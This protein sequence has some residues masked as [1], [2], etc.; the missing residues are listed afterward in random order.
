MVIKLP[1]CTP[2]PLSSYLKALGVLRL[3]SEA[4]KTAKVKG[5]WQDD[6]FVLVSDL[7]KDELKQ[8][9][10]YEYKPTPLVAPWNGSTGFYPKDNRKTLDSIANAQAERLAE[11]R[12]TVEVAQKQVDAL[13]LLEQPKE[14]EQKKQLLAELR[15][16]LPDEAV[17]WVETCALI[18]EEKLEF[19]PLTGTGGNDGN[20]EFSRTFMQQ[21][22]ELMNFATGEPSPNAQMLLRAAIFGEIVPELTFSGKIG[23]FNPI[24][25]GGANAAP[26]F[27]ADSR[28][29]PWDFVLMLEGTLLFAAG[30]TRRYEQTGLGDFVYPFTVKPSR[31]GYGSASEQDEARA[32]I[33]IPLWSKP[34]GIKELQI[35][36]NEGRAKIGQRTAQTGVDFARAISNLGVNRGISEFIRYSFQVRNGLSYFAMPLGRFQPRSNPQVD[37][38]AILDPWLLNFTQAAKDSEAP[39]SVKLARRQLETAIIDLTRDKASLLDVLIALGAAEK[40]LANSLK[41]AIAKRLQ[42]LPILRSSGWLTDC[43]KTDS[44]REFRLALSLTTLG[45]QQRRNQFQLHPNCFLATGELR[46]RLVP[47]RGNTPFWQEEKDG[48]TTWQAGS[49]LKNLIALLRRMEIETE[50]QEKQQPA[51]EEE[52]ARQGDEEDGLP[53]PPLKLLAN[54]DDITAWIEGAT[55]DDRIEAIARGLSLVRPYRQLTQVDEPQL[56][57]PTA[58]AMLAVVHNR[59]LNAEA[60]NEVFD[61]ELLRNDVTLPRVPEL[62]AKLAA[63]DCVTA[64]TLAARRLHASGLRPA[65]ASG[66]HEPG[67]RTRRIAAAL[68]FPISDRDTAFL[69]KQIRKIDSKEE[70][71]DG[72]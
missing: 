60:V 15:N 10:L 43:D 18:T 11:Y 3:I 59:F 33:W 68:A 1:G 56:K 2:E 51:S 16:H 23:Q 44:P 66:F 65:I 17:K 30:A 45:Q 64:T 53:K 29:N 46:Q 39:A 40:A 42:P 71:L 26:G 12:N 27:M 48:I 5:F 63:G 4:N 35:L 54:L 57:P 62:L 38:L 37:R 13:E 67:D 24:A 28:V 52:I 9:F 41:F 22:Q 19:P 69:L 6:I 34:V 31:V 36:F 55:N 49:L 58:Y 72:L 8:F 32:E 25:A 70:N 21:L 7:T 61:Y 14:R 20:F 47:V 50:R